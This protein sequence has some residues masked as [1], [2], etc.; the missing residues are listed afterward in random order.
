M[1]RRF[2]RSGIPGLDEV[3]GGGFLE[4]SIVAVSGPTGSGKSTFASQFLYNG[5]SQYD[6]PGL[7]IAIEESRADFFFHM[8]GLS[9]TDPAKPVSRRCRYPAA[10]CLQQ[11]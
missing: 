10:K 9:R 1:E 3:L 4:G 6:E 5:A 8:G 2:I 11:A 7:Y